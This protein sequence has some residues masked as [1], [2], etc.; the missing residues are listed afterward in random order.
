MLGKL[1][2]SSPIIYWPSDF[3][4]IHNKQT[5]Y[6]LLKILKNKRYRSSH[7]DITFASVSY[8]PKFVDITFASV[9]NKQ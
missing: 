7:V 5:K 8:K 3:F 2:L 9:S 4:I 1:Y 6:T